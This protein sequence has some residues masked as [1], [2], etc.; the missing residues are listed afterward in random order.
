MGE[1]TYT[2]VMKSKVIL[3]SIAALALAGSANFISH[4]EA[5]MVLHRERRG[6]LEVVQQFRR[7]F[8][9]LSKL[10]LISNFE[11]ECLENT[12]CPTFVD[13]KQGAENIYGSDLFRRVFRKPA[14]VETSKKIFTSYFRCH[15]DSPNC[16]HRGNNCKCNILVK[17][18]LAA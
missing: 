14:K 1:Y 2:T 8:R 18:R 10:H 7:T 12:V 4:K 6:I 5:N 13:F 16:R 3:V 15:R 17:Q 9:Q 11:R